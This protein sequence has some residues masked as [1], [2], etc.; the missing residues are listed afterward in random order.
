M[1]TKLRYALFLLPALVGAPTLDS[2]MTGQE[3]FSGSLSSDNRNGYE[4][5]G[6]EPA[7]HWQMNTGNRRLE[8]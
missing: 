8:R 4:R 7:C 5:G 1:A 2:T 6:N 3:P